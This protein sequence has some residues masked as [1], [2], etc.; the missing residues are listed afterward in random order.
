MGAY[1]TEGARA[2]AAAGPEVRYP[3]GMATWVARMVREAFR[4]EMLSD[5]LRWWFAADGMTQWYALL[6][7]ELGPLVGGRRDAERL[8][9]GL[10]GPVFE[11]RYDGLRGA[12]PG[13]PSRAVEPRAVGDAMGLLYRVSENAEMRWV[14]EPLGGGPVRWSEHARVERWLS[15]LSARARWEE[16]TCHLGE[17]LIAL[18]EGLGPAVDRH[19]AVLGRVCF[20]AGERVGKRM[21]KAFDL[22]ATPES[23][24]EVLRMSEYVFRVNPEHH[25]GAGAPGEAYLEGN[26][27]PWYGAAG[28]NGGHCGIFGQFQSGISSVFDLRYQLTKTI[29]KHGGHTCRVDLRPLSEKPVALGRRPRREV[30]P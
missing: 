4:R 8:L 20:A 5:R 6:A 29:P 13:L 22:P 7:R 21:K 18:T 27:C 23:A 17:M 1:T 3:R 16:V 28:W 10:L 2:L 19:H 26:A 11:R 14:L 9:S 24:I 15:P 25:S 30:S 12:A